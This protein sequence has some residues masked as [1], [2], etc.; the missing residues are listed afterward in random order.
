[1]QTAIP[2][3]PP[4]L[5]R[6]LEVLFCQSVK[7]CL[8]LGLDLLNVI[9]LES[10][11]LQFHFWN[12]KKSQSDKSGEYGGWGMTAI[13]YFTRNC[14]VRTEVWDGKLLRWSN[15]VCSRQSSGRSLRTFSRSRSRTWSSQFGLLG[16]VFRATT[17][18]VQMAAPVRNSLDTF[19]FL[20]DAT[21]RCELWS[22]Q[23]LSS[24]SPYLFFQF[25]I[26]TVCRSFRMSSSHLILGLPIG[27][28][29]NG[30]H[31]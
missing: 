17:T 14:W 12:W 19:F 8:W 6:F 22:A 31:L 11:Q 26:L 9:K 15:Q 16:P 1:M 21:A 23:R 30:F 4:F 7:H 29:A 27:L 3:S 10:F 13:L 25:S 18:A 20:I 2:P 24:K 5:E 28:E